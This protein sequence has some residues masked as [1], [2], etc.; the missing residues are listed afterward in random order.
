MGVLGWIRRRRLARNVR[1]QAE[2]LSEMQAALRRL[3]TRSPQ[4][5][6]MVEQELGRTRE[7]AKLLRKVRTRAELERWHA[8][9]AMCLPTLRP[10]VD[11]APPPRAPRPRTGK[12]RPAGRR[13]ATRRR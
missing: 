4:L 1:E 9:L 11:S 13:A 7:L 2:G 3:R 8:L 5:R 10:L 12:R 6:P